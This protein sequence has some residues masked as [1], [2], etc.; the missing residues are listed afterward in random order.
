MLLLGT[1]VLARHVAA[2]TGN[3]PNS[4]P[5]PYKLQLNWPQLPAEIKWAQVIGFD[6]DRDGNIYAFHRADPGILKFSSDGKFLKGWG[7]GTFVM[8]HGIT[9]DRFGYIWT[10]DADAKDGKGAQVMKFDRDG[11][12]LMTLGKAGVKAPGPDT[13]VGPTWVVVGANGDI[14]V[15]DG[16]G[17]LPAGS[18]HRILK[19]SK[20]GKFIKEWGGTGSGN[21]QLNDPHGMAM[22]STGRIF[23]A[24]R[25]N[26]RIQVFDQ[27]GNFV[28]AWPQFGHPEGLFIT[29]DDTLYVTDSNSRP[30]SPY[31]RGIRVGSAKDGSVR[32]FIP[33]DSVALPGQMGTTGPVGLGVDSKGN[34]FAADVGTAV[35]F[36]RM[37]KKYAR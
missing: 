33:Q 17:R 13:F 15:S 30:E 28:A 22:D 12:L 10:A 37:V 34:I 26:Q 27:E 14:F 5:N 31:K 24:D 20:D 6:V 29:A 4:Q 2:Q 8:A 7:S 3:A 25:G 16:H 1:I 19:F 23:V 9:V 36:D 35:G 21:G 32:Y 11:K 18:N